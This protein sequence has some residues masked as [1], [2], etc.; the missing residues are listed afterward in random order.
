VKFRNYFRCDLHFGFWHVMMVW[1]KLIVSVRWWG[2][3]EYIRGGVVA[4]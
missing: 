3:L 1:Y 4:Q 2:V